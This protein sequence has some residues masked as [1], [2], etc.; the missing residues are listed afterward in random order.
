[1]TGQTWTKCYRR[2]RLESP[3]CARECMLWNNGRTRRDVNKALCSVN[4]RGEPT[5]PAASPPTGTTTH[6]ENRNR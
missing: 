4:H 1:M 3:A 5:T 2:D 6:A